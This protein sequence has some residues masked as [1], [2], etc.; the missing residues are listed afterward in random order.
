[1]K[2]VL[3]PLVA[4]VALSGC[5]A[6]TFYV[7]GN[8]NAAP[9]QEKMQTFWI[10]GIG[11]EQAIDAARVCGGSD[12]VVKVE[13]QQTFID[14]LLGMVTFGIYTPRDAKVFCKR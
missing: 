14:G 9:T 11:Q 2:K 1:M 5:A 4:A 13:T 12:K 7:N 3:L 6:Q 8:S 10:Y